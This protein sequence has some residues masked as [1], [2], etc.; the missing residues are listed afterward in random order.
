MGWEDTLDARIQK[1]QEYKALASRIKEIIDD[2]KFIEVLDW[3][4]DF[5]D[6][7]GDLY[8]QREK[9]DVEISQSLS[10]AKTLRKQALDGMVEVYGNEQRAKEELK[11]E[12]DPLKE[13][14]QNKRRAIF[15]N[16]MSKLSRPFSKDLSHRWAVN[17]KTYRSAAAACRRTYVLYA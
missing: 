13:S 17:S 4:S 9:A 14:H 6:T 7:I 10:R 8:L 12:Y 5:L 15:Y 16:I 3:A 11:K 1:M 2:D